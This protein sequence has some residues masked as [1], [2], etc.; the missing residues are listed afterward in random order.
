MTNK[1]FC[2]WVFFLVYPFSTFSLEEN[3]SSSV[4]LTINILSIQNGKGLETDRHVL[5]EALDRMGYTTR[6]VEIWES[7]TEKREADINIFFEMISPDQLSWAP[8]NWFIPNPEW[9]RQ[10]LELL[11]QCD[12]ILCRTKEVERIF[13]AM[14]KPTHFLGFSSPDSYENRIPKSYS[15]IAH[16]PGGNEQKG[17]S[18][19]LEVWKRNPSF[20]NLKIVKLGL[21]LQDLPKNVQHIPYRLPQASFRSLQNFCGIHVCL[22][23]TEG[24]GHTIVEAMS[25]GAVV[26]TT[27]A[28]PMNEFIQDSRCLVP[29]QRTSSQRLATNYYVDPDQLEKKIQY[30]V[31]LPS[32]ELKSIGASNRLTY[33]KMTED[34]YQRLEQLLLKTAFEIKKARSN[35]TPK[36][37][38]L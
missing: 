24:F 8:I 19:I 33:L 30:L 12:L 16:L 29:Y 37:N 22:S 28:P 20:P 18:A 23:E 3:I 26:V 13:K 32:E 25:T 27:D 6:S 5:K 11:D 17:T 10:E 14:N 1:Q 34:F 9:Y 21:P 36:E 35:P 4:P 31:S 7:S 15:V 38:I 2:L